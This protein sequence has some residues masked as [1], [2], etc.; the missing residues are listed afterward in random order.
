MMRIAAVLD[1][2]RKPAL[3]LVA[4]AGLVSSGGAVGGGGSPL[5]PA[6]GP[7]AHAGLDHHQTAALTGAGALLQ[8]IFTEG[9][10]SRQPRTDGGERPGP[11]TPHAPQAGSTPALGVGPFSPLSAGPSRAGLE[12][13]PP[14]GPPSFPI[15][16]S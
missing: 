16:L 5:G 8:G 14:R 1:R 10:D 6:A 2:L 3:A 13:A 9:P 11:S 4:A 7:S 12:T 15:R